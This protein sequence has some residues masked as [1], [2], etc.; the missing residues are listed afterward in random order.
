MNEGFGGIKDVLLWE[1]I[2]IL[3]TVLIKVAR[4]LHIVKEQIQLLS[5]T[6]IFC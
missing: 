5:S 2:M 3:L 6:A 4:P 1:E